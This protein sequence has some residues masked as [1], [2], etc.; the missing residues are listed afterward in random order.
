MTEWLSLHFTSLQ[1]LSKN[2]TLMTSIKIPADTVEEW[3][4]HLTWKA[5]ERGGRECAGLG[6]L[7]KKDQQAKGSSGG[8]QQSRSAMAAVRAE[9][10]PELRGG[11]GTHVSHQRPRG[12][13][14]L[15][16]GSP[17][18]CWNHP[19]FSAHT[20]SI[21][22]DDLGTAPPPPSPPTTNANSGRLLALGGFC[23]ELI[24]LTLS[25]WISWF[26]YLIGSWGISLPRWSW[27]WY[28]VSDNSAL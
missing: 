11:A 12:P 21:P 27:C 7:A 4:Q 15:S 13:G 1:R 14:V 22:V 5:A 8:S 3:G 23:Y 9:K 26:F 28:L 19:G 10:L 6:R 2:S 24:K 20:Q 16:P 17:S 18:H 25:S